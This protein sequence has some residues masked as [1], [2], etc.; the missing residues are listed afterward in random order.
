M[1][2]F[3][4]CSK[5]PKQIYNTNLIFALVHELSSLVKSWR[6]NYFNYWHIGFPEQVQGKKILSKTLKPL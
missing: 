2:S 6:I 5:K 3:L 1:F 4:I